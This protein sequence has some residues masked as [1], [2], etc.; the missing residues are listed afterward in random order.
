MKETSEKRSKT[1]NPE[2]IDWFG[3]A[4]NVWDKAKKGNWV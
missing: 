4:K 3:V 1:S 2:D